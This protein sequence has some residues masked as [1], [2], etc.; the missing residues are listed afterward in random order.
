MLPR[1]AKQNLTFNERGNPIMRSN[2]YCCVLW[3]LA[4]GFG[5]TVWAQAEIKVGLLYPLSGVYAA[6]GK[7]GVEGA[8]L[9]FEQAGS[10]IGGHKIT[11]ITEDTE[12]Q[13]NVA[14]AKAK[15]L[16]ESDRVQLLMGIIWSPNAMALRAYVHENKI[17]FV[18]DP[19]GQPTTVTGAAA[20]SFTNEIDVIDPNFKYPSILRGNFGYD[21]TLPF[22]FVG[23]ADFVWS[24]TM[25]DIKYQNLNFQPVAG[26][27]GVGGRQFFAKKISSLSDVILLENTNKGYSYNFSYEIRRP[28]S[29]G[30][31]MQG[32]YSWGKS[33]TIMDGTS[34]QAASNWGNVYVPG[35]P[36]DAPLATS[37]FDPGHRITLTASY[38]VPVGKVVKPVLSVFYS[39][40]TG[41]PYTLVYSRDVNG[42]A[43]GSNDL[44]YIP[45]ANDNLTYTGGTY[46]DFINWINGDDCLASYV[47][48]ILP[49]NACRAPWTNHLD[50]RLAIQLPY[51]RFKT[52]VT[53]DAFNL[54]NLV[55]RKKGIIQYP[56]FNDILQPGTV[57]TSVTLTAPLTGYNIGTLVSPTFNRFSRDDLRSRWQIQLG[58]RI[59]F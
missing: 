12:L 48:Q 46:Q 58:A 33:R 51:K 26:V 35:N 9:A 28:F 49:R 27:T 47:G 25:K 22:G 24:K 59:R 44:V 15:K 54:I 56:F 11:L 42:D 2:R 6:P 39:G 41:R 45:T 38:D 34:D 5:G 16:V 50:G 19:L 40:Q 53:L 20:G 14:L 4:L 29:H 8:T 17:P 37:N 13:P 31:F 10:K 52:E 36:N 3:A 43:R 1:A 32:S 21:H 18:T 57:P 23:I 55:N 30:L 7:Q